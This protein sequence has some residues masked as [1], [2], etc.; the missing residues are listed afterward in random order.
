MKRAGNLIPHI[1][2][3]DNLRLAFWK[4][5]KG[6]DGKAAVIA[7]R[8]ELD[9]NLLQLRNQLLTG[10]VEVGHYHYFTIYDPKER[11]ICAASFPERVLHHALMNGCQ[12]VFENFQI[13]DS[14]ATRK[15]KGTYAALHRA[16]N[17]QKK[18]R[19]YLKLDIRKYFDSIDQAILLQLLTKRFKDQRLLNIFEQIILSYEVQ[20]G[21]GVPIGNLTSQYFANF[22]LAFADRFIK[23]QLKIPA[24][25]R[26]MDD[27][28]L[29]HSDKEV[30]LNAREQFT[31]FLEKK[32]Q[33]ALKIAQLNKSTQGL[34]FVGYRVFPNY[35]KL[36]LRSKKRFKTKM[37]T[38]AQYLEDGIWSQE[39]YQRH[40]LPLLAFTQHAST[41]EYRKRI[42]QKIGQ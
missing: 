9:Q 12:E 21:K 38:Y 3:M 5:R 27:M 2:D 40:I 30:L 32:L 26:Y 8:K 11:V 33:L 16:Q 13:Y 10:K 29:W 42:L 34:P 4:A 39:D 35:T 7:Y 24:Y 18:Y 28:V 36:S 1:A 15:G 41:M 23:E 14:Y 31:C 6:K 19:W 20:T 22:Y 37:V 17:F 25:V